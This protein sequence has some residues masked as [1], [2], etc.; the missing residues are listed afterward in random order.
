MCRIEPPRR[1]PF[2]SVNIRNSNVAAFDPHRVPKSVF[3]L[4]YTTVNP[5]TRKAP[6]LSTLPPRPLSNQE[7][8]STCVPNLSMGS[9]FFVMMVHESL[10][11]TICGKSGGANVLPLRLRASVSRA[12]ASIYLEISAQNRVRKA[13]HRGID[14]NQIHVLSSLPLSVVSDKRRDSVK[15]EAKPTPHFV[16]KFSFA[17]CALFV[18]WLVRR[19][20]RSMYFS[21]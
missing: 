3:V 4:V 20:K 9:I 17:A 12:W 15:R 16:F 1:V 21:A 8:G 6:L 18:L 11:S 5:P 13:Q 10:M 2:L 14:L 19:T 7:E